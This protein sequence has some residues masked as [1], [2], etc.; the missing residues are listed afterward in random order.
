MGDKRPRGAPKNPPSRWDKVL[1]KAAKKLFP[2]DAQGAAVDA[3][4]RRIAEG[5]RS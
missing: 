3:E 4:L 1:D 2:A 5:G